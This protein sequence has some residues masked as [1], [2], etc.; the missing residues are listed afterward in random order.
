MTE[1]NRLGKS[2]LVQITGGFEL[3]GFH[4]NLIINLSLIF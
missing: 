1:K 3:A 4:C 2:D